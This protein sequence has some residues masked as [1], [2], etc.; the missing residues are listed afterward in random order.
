MQA[1][2]G[3]PAAVVGIDVQFCGVRADIV[4]HEGKAGHTALSRMNDHS[5]RNSLRYI[6]QRHA[7]GQAVEGADKIAKLNGVAA[8]IYP[9][10][11][12]IH[13]VKRRSK[14]QY[15]VQA[16]NAERN[17]ILVYNFGF[18]ADVIRALGLFRNAETHAAAVVV[19]IGFFGSCGGNCY[20][21]RIAAGFVLPNVYLLGADIV[22]CIYRHV[23]E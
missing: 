19:I 22:T 21:D 9:L 4:A 18:K 17:L 23:G 3:L 14:A 10:V 6:G 16:R 7:F 20:C 15:L 1:G 13:V 5:E 2:V 12:L 8:L 11:Y